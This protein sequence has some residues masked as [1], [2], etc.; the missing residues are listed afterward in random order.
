MCVF[1]SVPKSNVF[2]KQGA[3]LP[4]TREWPTKSLVL[5]TANVPAQG[6]TWAHS[7]Q[8]VVPLKTFQVLFQLYLEAVTRYL[9]G[10]SWTVQKI[11]VADP[12]LCL[13]HS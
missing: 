2:K 10:C 3:T 9:A 8:L 7:L 1:T 5:G 6:R 13:Y 4:F 12:S 11:L